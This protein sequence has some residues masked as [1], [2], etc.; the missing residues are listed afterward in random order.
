VIIYVIDHLP[1]FFLD[2]SH[3]I[4]MGSVRRI[5]QEERMKKAN[6]IKTKYLKTA[7]AAQ[8]I[9]ISPRYLRQ[10]VAEGRVPVHKLGPRCFVFRVEDLE[11]FMKDNRIGGER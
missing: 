1:E 4:E 7:M 8:Y 5:K 11:T 2:A 3:L 10:L 9:G 6:A